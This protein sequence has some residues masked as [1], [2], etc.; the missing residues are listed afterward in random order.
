MF[1]GALLAATHREAERLLPAVQAVPLR[2]ADAFHLALAFE[3]DAPSIV[4][5]DRRL[6]DAARS[7]GLAAFP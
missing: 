1:G 5:F 3:G 4:T 2:A 6:A 7:V